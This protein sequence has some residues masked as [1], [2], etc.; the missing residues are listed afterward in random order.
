MAITL[1]PIAVDVKPPKAYATK[2]PLE[3]QEASEQPLEQSPSRLSP[4]LCLPAELRHKIYRLALTDS[5]PFID[6]CI[7]SPSTSTIKSP[8]HSIPLL[9]LNLLRTCRQIHTEATSLAYLHREN[10]FQFT[11]VTHC[12]SFLSQLGS[13]RAQEIR[14]LSINLRL[15]AQGDAATAH[16]WLAYTSA[17]ACG[18]LWTQRRLGTLR[19]DLPNLRCVRLDLSGWCRPG[20]G[21]HRWEYF[22]S[23]ARGLGGLECV[24]VGGEVKL[25]NL[26]LAVCE[27]WAPELFLTNDVIDRREGMPYGGTMVDLMS[28]A[29]LRDGQGEDWGEKDLEVLWSIANGK[30]M[31]ELSRRDRAAK[32]LSAIDLNHWTAPWTESYRR[33]PGRLS[34]SCTWEEY[35]KQVNTYR[36]SPSHR[37]NPTREE[38][39]AMAMNGYLEEAIWSSSQS[40]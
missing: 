27:P 3:P 25:R 29:V 30:V 10:I 1:E 5:E 14:I 6:P 31:L 39:L 35:Q 38:I 18:G 13:S 22:R 9:S 32:R 17:D 16:E 19:T 33:C 2:I 23:I 4:L 12:H 40:G 8:F 26:E 37:K 34:S 36:P 21:Q 28:S 7:Y 24:A 11:T 20:Y 15:V